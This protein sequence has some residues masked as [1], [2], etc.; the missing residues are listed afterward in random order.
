MGCHWGVGSQRE[1]E[2][3]AGA[4]PG[5]GV[6]IWDE[7]A[8]PMGAWMVWGALN[9]AALK[10]L[11]EE[12]APWEERPALRSMSEAQMSCCRRKNKRTCV[13]FTCFRRL[14]IQWLS[15]VN[16]VVVSE[17]GMGG[18]VESALSTEGVVVTEAH[19]L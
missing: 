9:V 2:A 14:H 18:R 10:P 17:G 1:K 8:V 5:H 7:E 6:V 3:A 13:L 15:G 19:N 4:A 11:A 12:V 16:V